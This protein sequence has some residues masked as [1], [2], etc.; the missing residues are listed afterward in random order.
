MFCQNCG[1]QVPD[2]S[3][4]CANCGTAL[5]APAQ[6]PIQQPI[7]QPVQQ[8]VYAAPIQQPVYTAPVQQPIQQPIY[9][10]PVQQQPYGM[11]MQQPA[12][13]TPAKRKMGKGAWIAIIASIVA[14]VAAA[15]VLLIVLL[16]GGSS[17]PEAVAEQAAKAL[18]EYDVDMMA[19]LLHQDALELWM[20]E[21]GYD[22]ID[23]MRDEVSDMAEEAFEE[24]A[25]ALGSDDY[26]ITY[27]VGS[28]KKIKG[29][30]LSDIKELYDDDLDLEVTAAYKV[31]VTIIVEGPNTKLNKKQPSRSATVYVVEIDGAWYLDMYHDAYIDVSQVSGTD[32]DDDDNDYDDDDYGDNNDDDYSDGDFDVTDA[33][34]GATDFGDQPAATEAPEA[35]EAPEATEAPAPVA[36]QAPVMTAQATTAPEEEEVFPIY[37]APE[38]IV[39]IIAYSLESCDLDLLYTTIPWEVREY[40]AYDNGFY[41]VRDWQTA[42]TED[43]WAYKMEMEA[44]GYSES[45]YWTNIYGA[46][47]IIEKIR[48]YYLELFGLYVEDALVVEFDRWLEYYDYNGWQSDYSTDAYYVIAIDGAWYADG[49]YMFCPLY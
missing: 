24:L 23:E 29:S 49:L 13:G 7:Q 31:P 45:Y 21:N 26:E 34:S 48:A 5:N 9:A 36:T 46:D 3:A 10:A 39:E 27:E 25:D 16:G 4:F 37:Y 42:A 32:P 1:T 17:T 30:D 22:S 41:D 15:A 40:I 11:P 43:Y 20:D 2:N 35:D 33:I 18:M 44:A 6:Q 12:Y 8:P 38:E 19:D 14:V 28:P 47:D